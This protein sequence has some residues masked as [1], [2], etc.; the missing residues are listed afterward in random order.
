[1]TE[2]VATNA[3]KKKNDNF[4]QKKKQFSFFAPEC[5]HNTI[6]KRNKLNEALQRNK[7]RI[8]F[9]L[10]PIP[11]MKFSCIVLLS[12]TK[13]LHENTALTPQHI[14]GAKTDCKDFHG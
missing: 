8:P 3:L 5:V 13:K 12:L 10:D 4:L 9:Y 11:L 6:E 14:I 2:I 7:Q 1:M